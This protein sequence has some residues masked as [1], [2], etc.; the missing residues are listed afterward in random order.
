MSLVTDLLGVG[1][2]LENLYVTGLHSDGTANAA[3]ALGGS[4][5]L[6]VKNAAAQVIGGDLAMASAA[7]DIEDKLAIITS[8]LL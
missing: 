2:S 8:E 5:V 7:Q 6:L 4:V 1:Q 3:L